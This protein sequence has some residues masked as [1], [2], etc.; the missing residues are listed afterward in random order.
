MLGNHG[1]KKPHIS[2]FLKIT[3]ANA[4]IVATIV[5]VVAFIMISTFSD[6]SLEKELLLGREAVNK[7]DSFTEEKYNRAYNLS[8]YMHTS[9]N[10]ATFFARIIKNPDNAY[11]LE[12]VR[13]IDSCLLS[14]S[15]DHDISEYILITGNNHVYATPTRGGRTVSPS[16]DFMNYQPVKELMTGKDSM[17]IYYDGSTPYISKNTE[18]VISFTGL[19]FDPSK[20]PARKIVGAYIM[21]IPASNFGYNLQDFSATLKGQICLV[22]REDQI[23]YS[24][25]AKVEGKQFSTIVERES[26]HAEEAIY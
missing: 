13:F 11:S 7:I 8:N 20:F 9:D 18:P 26:G 10:I 6:L 14:I 3:I 19:I 21:N 5:I 16:F 25:N 12:T 22:S 17:F 23:L 1:N 4:I 2:L 24:S 15:E